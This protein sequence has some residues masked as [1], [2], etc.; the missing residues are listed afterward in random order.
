MFKK[1]DGETISAMENIS[2]HRRLRLTLMSTKVAW[3]SGAME[4]E[5]TK[6]MWVC[7]CVRMYVTSSALFVNSH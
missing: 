1:Y 2:I 5:G 4:K 6:C 3:I 7:V